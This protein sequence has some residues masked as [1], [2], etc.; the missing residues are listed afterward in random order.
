MHRDNAVRFEAHGIYLALK[1]RLPDAYL[2][3]SEQAGIEFS[4]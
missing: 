4:Q 3:Q 2:I 1:E